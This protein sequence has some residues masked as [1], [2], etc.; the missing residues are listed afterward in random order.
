MAKKIVV[1][2]GGNRGIGFEICK[3]LHALDFQ[4]V[5][6]S[7]DLKKGEEAAKS[8]SKKN[9]KVMYMN[10]DVSDVESITT[11][12]NH[13]KELYGHVDV[14]VN[15]AGIF[16]DREAQ[17]IT[18]KL[19]KIKET[20]ETNTYGP[21]LLIQQLLPL[22]T[23]SKDARIINMSSGLGAISEMAGGYPG[24]RLSKVALNAATLMMAS[25][26]RNTTVKVNA[27]CPGWVKSDMGG[28]GASRSL[29]EG[30]DTA[31]WLATASG[32]PNGKFFR[33]RKEIDW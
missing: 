26:L 32:I 29:V 28:P 19:N 27:M 33:D 21:V 15:N 31:V 12:S 11:F 5:L 7:R 13:M 9:N 25:E 20:L 16:I 8:L 14:L 22:L 3:Q 30:A 17:L 2:T 23:L 1:V 24:Y 4:V 10:L 6:T 18:V